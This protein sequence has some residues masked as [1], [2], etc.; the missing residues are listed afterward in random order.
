M[1]RSIA[2]TAVV[3]QIAAVAVVAIVLAVL[4]P[5]SFFEDWGWLSG[6]VAWIAC[7]AVTAR[8]L[9]LPIVGALTGAVLAG[10]PSAIASSPACTGSAR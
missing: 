3:V 2:V 7:A 8:V 6:P 9:G 1:D 10:I 5:K 4:L